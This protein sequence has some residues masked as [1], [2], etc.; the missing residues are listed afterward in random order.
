MTQG[1]KEF[2]TNTVKSYGKSRHRLMDIARDIQ[3]KY[4]FI[5]DES[6]KLIASKLGIPFI[7]VIDMVSFYSF[8]SREKKGKSVIRLSKSIVDK[9]QG[10]DLVAKAFEQAVG[11]SFG[12]TSP[13]GKITLEYTSDIGMGDQA[14]AALVN[15]TVMTKLCPEDIPCI[16][17]A[18]KKG[19][20]LGVCTSEDAK[21]G[22][23]V[24]AQIDLNIVQPGQV[25]FAPYERGAAVRAAMNMSP[26]DVIDVIT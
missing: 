9:M 7:E 22:T 2:I 16:V 8:L 24:D 3:A 13:D 5:S 20:P 18:L 19:K 6:A 21:P 17:D 25:I 10:M 11:V 14:P 4:G 15:G 1:Q 23:R 26:E 12:Q